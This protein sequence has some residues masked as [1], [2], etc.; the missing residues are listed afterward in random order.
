LQ[1]FPF[2]QHVQGPLSQFTRD[3]QI[4]WVNGAGMILRKDMIH[5]IGLFDE[6]LVFISSDSDYCFTVRVRGIHEFGASGIEAD[7]EV[8]LLTIKDMLTFGQKWL[9][10]GLY[11][12][13]AYEG[14]TCT[15]GNINNLMG[16]MDQAMAELHVAQTE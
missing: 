3:E 16:R 11:K 13:L 2:G 4:F 1:A 5:E 10:C 9:T 14:S 6:S 8:K 7:D 15:M 12:K